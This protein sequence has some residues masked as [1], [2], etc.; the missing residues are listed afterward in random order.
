MN[1]RIVMV[2]S[3]EGM[4]LETELE[5]TT[6]GS[7]QLTETKHLE[8]FLAK[9]L[10]LLLGDIDLRIVGRQVESKLGSICDFVLLDKNGDLII[11]EIK[12]DAADCA[13]QESLEIQAIRY[14]AVFSSIKTR[15]DLIQKVYIPYLNKYDKSNVENANA[16]I[17]DVLG[18]DF[19]PDHFNQKQKIMLIASGFKPSI[20]S[21]CAWLRNNGIDISC[22]QI[23]PVPYED[24]HLL[25]IET[26]LPPPLLEDMID[27]IEASS[28]SEHEIFAIGST[29]NRRLLTTAD[30]LNQ[31]GWFKTGDTVYI[32]RDHHNSAIV[33]DAKFVKKDG[34]RITWNQWVNKAMNLDSV[35]IYHYVT[36][37]PGGETLH[38]I[39]TGN[40]NNDQLS[41][42]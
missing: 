10:N 31:E 14:A 5:S 6:F 27:S 11:V 32:K 9:N 41:L 7:M 39:R 16:L 13:R 28:K 30:M 24:K 2:T 26:I 3:G 22:V 19:K 15:E 20:L 33:L 40:I 1:S 25:V 4:A 36:L 29:R 18:K 38:G 37:K 17:E 21:S 12:R 8:P 23:S 34:N 35:S 42:I